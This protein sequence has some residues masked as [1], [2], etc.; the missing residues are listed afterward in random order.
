MYPQSNRNLN[1]NIGNNNN[2]LNNNVVSASKSPINLNRNKNEN[3]NLNVSNANKNRIL[4]A[5]KI[6]KSK[7]DKYRKSIQY[8]LD[9]FLENKKLIKSNYLANSK[10]KTGKNQ[11][12]IILLLKLFYF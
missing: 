4:S 8:Q 12:N 9:D 10:D 11:S 6:D 5:P 1:K 7:A 3:K 2:Y